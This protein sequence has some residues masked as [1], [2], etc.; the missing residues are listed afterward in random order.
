MAN[1]P[2]ISGSSRPRAS[3][4]ELKP[5]DEHLAALLNPALTRESQD[6]TNARNRRISGRAK[7]FGEAPQATYKAEAT[8]T[9]PE[10][11]RALGLPEVN[12]PA[13]P[14]RGDRVRDKAITRDAIL[15]DAP[16]P[17]IHPRPSLRDLWIG[18]HRASHCL[19]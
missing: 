4:P 9:D 10:L 5:L 6:D 8:I 13:V 11:A 1:P 12:D 19:A 7:G 17:S 15:A 16:R 14:H 2:K 18:P 3:R